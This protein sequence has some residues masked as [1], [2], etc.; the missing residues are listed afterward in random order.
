MACF[1][2][3]FTTLLVA[4]YAA[5]NG[6]VIN[7]LWIGKH[8]EGSGRDV[9][10]VLSQDVWG[11]EENQPSVSIAG[12]LSQIPTEYIQNMSLESYCCTKSLGS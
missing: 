7:E 8:L 10:E 5:S 12:V 2:N 3:Y 9:I 4:R 11:T 1:V 6:M